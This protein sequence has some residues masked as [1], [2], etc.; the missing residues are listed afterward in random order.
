MTV[1]WIVVTV[2]IVAGG[3]LAPVLAG[4]NRRASGGGAAAAARDRYQL[5]GHYVE[6]PV[7]TD[8]PEALALLRKGRERWNSAGAVLAD[9][10]APE[11]FA[12]AESVAQEGLAHV[13]AAHRKLGIPGPA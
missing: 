4:R 9:A 5:L 1:V 10:K 8:D 13:T 7:G 2:V 3:A 12:L 6:D 11:D